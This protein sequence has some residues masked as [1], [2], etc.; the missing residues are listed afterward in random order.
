MNEPERQVTESVRFGFG[1]NWAR[2]LAVV[3]DERIAIAEQ[4][5]R[6]ML[7]VSSLEGRRFID[8]GSGSGLFSLA[9][10][11]LGATV[12]SFDYD[13]ESVGCTQVLRERYRPG[14]DDWRIERGDVLD[15]DYLARFG[16]FDVVYSWGVLH[17][18]GDMWR[19]LENVV[20]LVAPDGLLYISIYNDQGRASRIWK[21]VKY[22]YNRLPRG[23][24]WLVVAP[25]LVR[26]WGPASVRDLLKGRPFATWRAKK[27]SRGMS[28]MTDVIDWVGGWPFEVARPDAIF[29]FYRERGF[30]LRKLVTKRGSGCNEFVF[31]LPGGGRDPQ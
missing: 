1:E 4:G 13:P 14:D 3:D 25:A 29:D 10:R 23:L 22:L 24:R 11:N 15:A 12:V 17:H 2:F 27:K 30:E 6:D 26:L 21:R 16:E 28:P 31:L 18:T 7:D 9:A 20:P 19:A 8:V 5:L